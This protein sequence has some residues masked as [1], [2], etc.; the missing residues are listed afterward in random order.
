ME[1]AMTSLT[2]YEITHEYRSALDKLAELDL[3]EDV[4]A[5]TLESLGG[6]LQTK[7]TSVAAFIRNLE[8]SA[9]AIKEAESQMAAR[10]KAIENRAAR[11]KDYLLANMMVAGVQKIE[12]P[13]FKLSVRENPPAVE[14]FEP[15]IIPAQFMKQPE[16][17]PPMPNKAE[18]KAAIQ[19][20][21]DVPGCVLVRGNRL[22]IK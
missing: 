4:V 19:A 10:R 12:S 3:P 5:D 7:A 2:L 21:Q 1:N 11:V 14:I 13:Y 20:G 22:E 16:T 17:P 15:G 8:A 6:E 18:I 9:G